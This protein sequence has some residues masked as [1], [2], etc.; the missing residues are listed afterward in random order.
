[1]KALKFCANGDGKPVHFPS[2]VLCKDCF[3]AVFNSLKK[4]EKELKNEEK[5]EILIKKNKENV[6]KI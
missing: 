3:R 2:K 6:C 5:I 4:I 1:M